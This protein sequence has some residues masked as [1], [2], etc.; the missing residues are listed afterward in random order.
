MRKIEECVYLHVAFLFW[1]TCFPQQLWSE[2]RISF[3][4]WYVQRILYSPVFCSEVYETVSWNMMELILIE[5]L[6]KCCLPSTGAYTFYH[7]LSEYKFLLF[8]SLTVN[9]LYS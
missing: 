5:N 1:L 8:G 7:D 4:S 3:S 6:S 9:M 2:P